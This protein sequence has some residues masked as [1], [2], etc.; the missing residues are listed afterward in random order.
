M[1]LKILHSEPIVCHYLCGFITMFFV[2][3][4]DYFNYWVIIRFICISSV[5]I[6]FSRFSKI[7]YYRFVMSTLKKL[8]LLFRRSRLDQGL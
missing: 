3:V 4:G 1:P 6:W 8:Y 7:R 5:V 2:S